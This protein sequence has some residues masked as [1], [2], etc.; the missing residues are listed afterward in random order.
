MFLIE[1]EILGGEKKN[2]VPFS[3]KPY[4]Y[5]QSHPQYPLFC[6]PPLFILNL[7]DVIEYFY[8]FSLFMLLT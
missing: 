6:L 4:I 2:L 7:H 8:F 1:E 3:Q 5:R